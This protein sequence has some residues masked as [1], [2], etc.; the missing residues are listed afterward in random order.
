MILNVLFHKTVENELSVKNKGGLRTD[1]ESIS[2]FRNQIQC[3][4][5]RQLCSGVNK[6]TDC[7]YNDHDNDNNFSHL[8]NKSHV[9]KNKSHVLKEGFD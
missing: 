7:N 6:F 1:S 9:L 3:H 5:M 4:K 2:N 8:K